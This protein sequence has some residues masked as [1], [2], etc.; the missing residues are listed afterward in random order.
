MHGIN[1]IIIKHFNRSITPLIYNLT[2]SYRHIIKYLYVHLHNISDCK[3][4][5]EHIP[6]HPFIT[7]S[8]EMRST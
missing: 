7:Q 8:P 4:T 6:S 5:R 3:I 2:N 1:K